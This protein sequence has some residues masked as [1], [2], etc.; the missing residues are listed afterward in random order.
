[1]RI[2]IERLKR[3]WDVLGGTII[4]LVSSFLV[5]WQ[6]DKI[7][8]IYSILILILLYIGLLKVLAKHR[9][10]VN[11]NKK[12]TQLVVEEK[13]LVDRMVEVQKPFK[14]LHYAES[15]TQDGEELG[16][17]ILES[18][19]EGQRGMEK[20]KK[21][22]KWIWLY[23][24]QLIGLLGSLVSA[25]LVVYAYIHDKFGWLLQYFPQTK[26]W[27]IGVK[28]G[29]GV[30]ALL[31]VV[32]G[33]RNQCKWVGFGS[34]EKAKE[35]L[36]QLKTSVNSKLSPEAKKVVTHAIKTLKVEEK[37]LKAKIV[38]L[39]TELEAKASAMKPLQ[40]LLAIG[41][42]DSNQLNGLRME[43]STMESE[44]TQLENQLH[45]LEVEI[46]RYNQALS[47]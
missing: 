9:K 6:V 37:N 23:K 3:Y 40:E 2:L 4:G 39:T 1:M 16:N 46:E 19:K 24:E 10:K 21:F 36:D 20:V 43:Y 17:L 15:P 28:I 30:V 29:V 11:K 47:K 22:F 35:Y 38:K 13:R 45:N 12:E 7:Q 18:V 32:F 14:A 34:V 5:D 31:F 44:K 26:G 25:V 33:V 41:Y 27:E 8:L 42:G